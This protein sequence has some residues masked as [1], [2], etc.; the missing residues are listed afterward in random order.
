MLP[1]TLPPRGSLPLTA[2]SL[3]LPRSRGR[4]GWGQ[5]AVSGG[6]GSSGIGRLARRRSCCG[7]LHVV[8]RDRGVERRL[9]TVLVGDLGGEIHLARTAVKR[10]DH[11]SVFLGDKAAPDLAR[12][13]D[14]VVVRVELLVEQQEATDAQSGGQRSVAFPDLVADQFAHLGL[15]AQILERGIGEGVPLGPIA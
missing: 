7:I 15:R 3:T 5:R 2:P 13:G 1:L 8:D 10:L 11:G 6:P 4:E 14:F 12:A 9:A